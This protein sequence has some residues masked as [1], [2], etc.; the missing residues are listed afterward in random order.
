M[1]PYRKS[2]LELLATRGRPV[3]RGT[4]VEYDETAQISRV[5]GSGMAAIDSRGLKH[6]E[7]KK[8]DVERG[9]DQKERW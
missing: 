6:P 9:E 2:L 5:K 8:F 3:R 7:T 4:A 1:H